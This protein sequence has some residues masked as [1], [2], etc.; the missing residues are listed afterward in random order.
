MTF[1]F[2]I[3]ALAVALIFA[4]GPVRAADDG[5]HA[6]KPE[7]RREI[8]A[9]IDAQLAAFRAGDVRKAYRYAS[10]D[11]RAQKPIEAF[12][13]IVQENYPEIWANTRAEFGLVRDDG[14][15]ATLLVHVYGKDSD[16]AYD[17]TLV[18][19]SAGWRIAAVLRHA[20]RQSDKM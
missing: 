9:V 6:S 13:A 4:L 14:A 17:Y 18:K 8:V 7:V 3:A 20:P 19:E 10:T 2:R 12:A 5:P 15:T 11:L 1:F 16:A